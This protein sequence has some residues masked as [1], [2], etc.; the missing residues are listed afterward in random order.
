MAK[1]LTTGKL[2]EKFRTPS[3][4]LRHTIGF[5]GT[6]VPVPIAVREGAD[7]A[8]TAVILKGWVHPM[9]WVMYRWKVENE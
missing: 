2:L 8:P 3:T 7:H 9:E 6:N 5:K 4:K 1:G